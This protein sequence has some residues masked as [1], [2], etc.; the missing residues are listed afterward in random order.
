MG[1]DMSVCPEGDG[2]SGAEAGQQ[3]HFTIWPGSERLKKEN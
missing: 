1:A 2:R 3:F